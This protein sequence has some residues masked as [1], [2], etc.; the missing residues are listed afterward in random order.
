[1][2]DISF[3]GAN[4]FT[5]TTDAVTFTVNRHASTAVNDLMIATVSCPVASNTTT[6][7]LTGWT[8]LY[9]QVLDATWDRAMVV[10]YRF[11]QSGDPSSWNGTFNGSNSANAVT[12]CCSY[13]GVDLKNPFLDHAGLDDYTAGTTIATA[14]LANTHPKAWWVAAFATGYTNNATK[15]WTASAGTER[16]DIDTTEGATSDNASCAMFD[17]NG[18]ATVGNI[19]ITGTHNVA[20]TSELYSW[21]G[22]LKPAYNSRQFM[23]FY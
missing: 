17:S 15:S 16:V 1:M 22:I 9:H 10:Y 13:R 19:S 12:G 21:L 20:S 23:T 6:D 14:T 2:P 4:T 7:T 18:A 11:M 3:I 5:R 8:K